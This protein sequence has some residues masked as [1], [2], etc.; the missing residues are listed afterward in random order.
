MV[1]KGW[2]KES[3]QLL[4]PQAL[5]VLYGLNII[6][7][8][9]VVYIAITQCYSNFIFKA[10]FRGFKGQTSSACGVTVVTHGHRGQSSFM[11]CHTPMPVLPEL[12]GKGVWRV[13]VIT[14]SDPI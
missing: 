1:S 12:K 14:G 7:I 11:L 13:R 8:N 9:T 2:C 6:R 5:E 10:I 3:S 4:L